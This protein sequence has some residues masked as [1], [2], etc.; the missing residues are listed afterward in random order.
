ML[1]Q[2]ERG[3]AI[4]EASVRVICGPFIVPFVIWHKDDLYSPDII[5]MKISKPALAANQ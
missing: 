5:F 3:V 4:T 1:L 2:D